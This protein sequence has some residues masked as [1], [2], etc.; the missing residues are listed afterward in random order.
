MLRLSQETPIVVALDVDLEA[1]GTHCSY[2]FR[3]FEE[4]T[5]VVPVNDTSGAAFAF[6][7]KECQVKANYSWHNIYFG[8]ESVLPPD[9]DDGTVNAVSAEARSSSQ[10]AYFEW[11]KTKAKQAK[12][13]NVLAARFIG[14]QVALETQK[15][16][17]D[18]DGPLAKELSE[19][20]DGNDLYSVQDHLERL[21]FTEG[22]VTDEEVNVIRDVLGAALPGLEQSIMEDKHAILV[23]KMS[24]NAIGVTP[25]GG[26]SDRVRTTT[27]THEWSMMTC[28]M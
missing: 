4:G 21:R 17:K 9:L 22:H 24:Y 1:K 3:G 11:R 15:L 6:C 8:N 27:G 19:M 14:K 23:G 25:N 16:S 7:S 28:R 5:A 12:Q 26:R 2:C 20:A 18:K 10:N 13:A